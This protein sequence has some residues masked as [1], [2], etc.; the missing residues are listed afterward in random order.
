MAETADHDYSGEE[1]EIIEE[2]DVAL[3]DALNDIDH[4]AYVFVMRMTQ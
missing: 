4:Y 2:P 3:S 1:V